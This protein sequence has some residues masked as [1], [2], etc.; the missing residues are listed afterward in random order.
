MV[1]PER[2]DAW[3]ADVEA[4]LREAIARALEGTA[5]QILSNG[6]AHRTPVEHETAPAPG[7]EVP[8]DHRTTMPAS[9]APGPETGPGPSR[10]QML[11]IIGRH[12]AQGQEHFG[13]DGRPL[14]S[15]EAALSAMEDDGFIIVGQRVA[16]PA[17]YRGV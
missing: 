8:V 9:P 14:T 16:L 1:G 12:M 11:E 3:Q 15:P 10:A 13:R 17:G 4:R 5:Q 2:E 6:F 7:P